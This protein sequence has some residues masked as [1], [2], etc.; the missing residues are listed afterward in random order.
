MRYVALTVA[1]I[2]LLTG[3]GSYPAPT[4][5]VV[6]SQASVRAAQEVGAQNNPQAAL[7][8]KLAQEQVTQ[9]QQLMQDGENKRAEFVLLRAESDAELAVALARESS[10]RAQAQQALDELRALKNGDK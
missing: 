1:G 9:A 8:L 2:A 3:C 5:H 4:E 10:A 7:H 6:T